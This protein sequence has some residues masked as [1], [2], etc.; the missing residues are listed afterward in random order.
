MTLLYALAIALPTDRELIVLLTFSMGSVLRNNSPKKHCFLVTIV[1]TYD[2][3]WLSETA[4]KFYALCPAQELVLD[5]STF[6]EQYPK[7]LLK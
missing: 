5:T 6:E 3:D 7:L 4:Y 1:Q 2:P